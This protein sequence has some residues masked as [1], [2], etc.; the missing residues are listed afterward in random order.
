MNSCNTDIF[1]SNYFHLLSVRFEMQWLR[2]LSIDDGNGN[3]RKQYD[4]LNEENNRAARAA[5]T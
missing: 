5:R 4:W 2:G 1:F 3:D